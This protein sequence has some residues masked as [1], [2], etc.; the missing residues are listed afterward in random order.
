MHWKLA[1]NSKNSITLVFCCIK[2]NKWQTHHFPAS[3]EYTSFLLTVLEAIATANRRLST[4]NVLFISSLIEENVYNIWNALFG[5][6]STLMLCSK[7]KQYGVFTPNG[8]FVC[9]GKTDIR[10]WHIHP[11]QKTNVTSS[12]PGVSSLIAITFNRLWLQD[13][14]ISCYRNIYKIYS[15]ISFMGHNILHT[16]GVQ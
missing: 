10:E 3:G 16:V 1:R 9:F 6:L 15:I 11:K 13:A 12:A 5:S 14:Q 2:R 4:T 8:G 7:F